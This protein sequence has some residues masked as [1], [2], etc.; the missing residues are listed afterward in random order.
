VFSIQPRRRNMGNKKLTAVSMGTG[1][2]H[3]QH[4]GLSCFKSGS[5]SSRNS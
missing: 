3:G 5:N 4:T 2:G 1:I